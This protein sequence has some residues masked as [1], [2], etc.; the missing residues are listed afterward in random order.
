MTET[1]PRCGGK[2]SP[3]LGWRICRKCDYQWYPMKDE[4]IPNQ[5]RE[6]DTSDPYKARVEELEEQLKQAR[7]GQ[8]EQARMISSMVDQLSKLRI[9]IANARAALDRDL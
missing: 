8:D 1:C 6:I 5:Y 7:A 3:N 2:G 9:R 4:D